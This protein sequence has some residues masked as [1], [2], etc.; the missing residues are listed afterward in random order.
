MNE[1]THKLIRTKTIPS[2]LVTFHLIIHHISLISNSKNS[3]TN[4]FIFS[5]TTFPSKLPS[6]KKKQERKGKKKSSKFEVNLFSNLKNQFNFFLFSFFLFFTQNFY[7]CIL[8]YFSSDFLFTS[9]RNIFIISK[10]K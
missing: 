9:E 10:K 4:Q 2:K 6:M 7:F 3:N 5:L 8:L 1:K